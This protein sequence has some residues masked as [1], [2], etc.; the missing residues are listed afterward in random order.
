MFRD[1]SVINWRNYND[2]YKVKGYQCTKCKKT[3]FDEKGLCV[4]GSKEFIEKEF[5][6]KGKILTFTQI[7]GAPEA[8][9]QMTPYCV[10]IIELEEGARVTAQIA[11]ANY[12]DLKIGL[13]VEAVF[14]KMYKSGDS[15][16]IHYGTKFVLKF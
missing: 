4:C 1:S 12:K 2:R 14:R 8:F 15:G 10:G 11:D 5:S 3:Y 7:H 13:E 16:A 9:T 6:G